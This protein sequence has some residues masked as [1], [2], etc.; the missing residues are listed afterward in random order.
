MR[1]AIWHNA[2]VKGSGKA[3]ADVFKEQ[4]AQTKCG[5]RL[6]HRHGDSAT[7]F[8]R[9]GQ[10]S[11]YQELERGHDG[12]AVKSGGIAFPG[13]ARRKKFQWLSKAGYLDGEGAVVVQLHDELPFL[14]ALKKEFAPI[15]LLESRAQDGRLEV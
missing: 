14:L 2:A 13:E 6:L 12:I 5:I 4:P 7:L 3:R 9:Q 15:P 11:I 8:G 1:A 10:G